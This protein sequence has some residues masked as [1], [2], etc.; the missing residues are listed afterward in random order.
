MASY[1]QSCIACGAFIDSDARICPKC[2]SRSPFDLRCPTC[3]REI[4]ADD[5]VCAG[6]GRSLEVACPSCGKQTGVSSQCAH[7]GT[8]LLIACPNK[9]CG[10]L[11][12]FDNPR[13]TSCGK[14]IKQK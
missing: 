5:T 13:C 2:R 11:Q 14:K 10:D 8:S 12:F 3:L 1:K 9:R 7:C 4:E 6:C